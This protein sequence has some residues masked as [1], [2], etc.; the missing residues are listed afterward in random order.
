MGWN[1]QPPRHVRLD[2]A[3]PLA[4]RQCVLAWSAA[5][6]SNSFDGQH[7]AYAGTPG[8]T[9][10]AGLGRSRTLASTAS[11]RWKNRVRATTGRNITFCAVIRPNNTTDSDCRI[12]GVSGTSA[13]DGLSFRYDA[14]T[15]GWVKPGVGAQ[16]SSVALTAGRAFF[17]A[18]AYQHGAGGIFDFYARDMK[19]GAV[20]TNQISDPGA[21]TSTA[22]ILDLFVGAQQSGGGTAFTGDV[23]FAATFLEALSVAEMRALSLNPW[24]LFKR[25][26]AG[27]RFASAAAGGAVK[28]PTRITLGLF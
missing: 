6:P 26:P 21:W 4:R 25:Q 7:A 28:L 10:M 5:T 8:Y 9:V 17:V 24:Q 22:A 18:V 27:V 1:T 19:S 20:Q 13:D 3:N 14:G 15:I 2:K 23:S 11:V 12:M 16:Q